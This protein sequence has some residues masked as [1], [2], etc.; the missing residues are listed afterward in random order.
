[1]IST[2][3]AT[4]NTRINA[5]HDYLGVTQTRITDELNLRNK[6]LHNGRGNFDRA[7]EKA[8]SNG[9]ALNNNFGSATT[10]DSN[11]LYSSAVTRGAATSA[12]V[13]GDP[14]IGDTQYTYL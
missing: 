9:A 10:S 12:L 2:N 3:A 14:H 6:Y 11:A 1:M 13:P 8:Y 5:I 4:Q 7:G